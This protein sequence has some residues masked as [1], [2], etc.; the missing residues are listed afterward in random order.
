MKLFMIFA[1]LFSM[2]SMAIAA[3]KSFTLS[4]PLPAITVPNSNDTNL[5]S[6]YMVVFTT[7]VDT[8]NRYVYWY[9]QCWYGYWLFSFFSVV[10]ALEKE[11]KSRG[12]TINYKFNVVLKGFS[13]SLDSDEYST[14]SEIPQNENYPFYI[15]ADKVVSVV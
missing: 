11:L 3:S 13:V 1:T 5:A 2:V 12:I 6:T 14:L 9:N 4:C 7:G 10:D 8:P 15:E